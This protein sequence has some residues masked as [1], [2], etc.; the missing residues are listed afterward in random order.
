MARLGMLQPLKHRRFRLLL[1]GQAVS[2]VGNWLDLL[3]LVVL[4]VYGW[5]LGPGAM[6]SVVVVSALPWL[7]VAPVAGV[8]ADR[9]PTRAV[10]VGCDLARAAV[11]LGYLLAPD[12]PVLLVLIAAK[13]T[14]S[15]LFAPA[16]QAA[17]KRVVPEEDL[18][19]AIAA[20][21]FVNQSAKIAG[22]VL[23]GVLVGAYGPQVVFVCDAVTF[24]VS[25]LFLA[26]LPLARPA[27]GGRPERTSFL[28][29]L[30]AG[31]VHIRRNGLLMAAIGAMTATT[32][33]IFVYDVLSPLALKELG[34]APGLLG[35]VM[36]GVGAGTVVGALLVGWAGDAVRPLTLMGLG[37]A[38]IGVAVAA[39]GLLLLT[40][41]RPWPVLLVGVGALTGLSS[42]GFMIAFPYVL[43]TATPEELIGRVSATA[44]AGPTAV[45]LVAPPLGALLAAYLGV[46]PVFTAAGIA[47][48]LLGLGLMAV[49][50]PS[51]TSQEQKT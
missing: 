21:T 36:A 9:L 41:V 47:L 3:G 27:G 11:V 50:A 35:V 32:F 24:V 38:G 49:R 20:T 37:Q 42:A 51:W 4:V 10:L 39:L 33:L 31:L 8:L 23:G 26:R 19:Q 34:A 17:V 15:A 48:A 12:L 25:A 16:E 29:E 28:T 44:N 1:T 22:P 6:A 18:L 43:Q 7:V 45:Q 5:N 30:T 2:A 14:L 13:S 40:G 46:G